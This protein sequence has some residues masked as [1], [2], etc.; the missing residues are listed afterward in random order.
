MLLKIRSRSLNS[1]HFFCLSLWCICTSMVSSHGLK[2][3]CTQFLFVCLF[4]CLIFFFISF[5]YQ[6]MSFKVAMLPWKWGQGHQNLNTFFPLSHLSICSSLVKFHLLIHE[7]E[8]TQGSLLEFLLCS[9]LKIKV[10]V[11]KIFFP[12]SYWCIYG[13]LVKF[14][15]LVKQLV[16]TQAFYF[17]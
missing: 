5:P 16:C 12:L 1:N 13:N 11:S 8:C 10:K 4:V 2:I 15:P 7:I 6:H 3:Q 14:Q 17:I 9:D